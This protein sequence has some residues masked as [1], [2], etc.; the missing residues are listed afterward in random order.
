MTVLRCNVHPTEPTSRLL[1]LSHPFFA[2]TDAAGKARLAGVPAGSLRVAAA[3]ADGS[4]G[5]EAV[6]L[7][8]GATREVRIVIE[9]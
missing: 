8:A 2:R 7:A 9:K 3:L 5:E 1:V 4:A 6:A